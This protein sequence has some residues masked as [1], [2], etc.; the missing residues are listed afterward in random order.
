M[1]TRAQI[2]GTMDAGVLCTCVGIISIW[3]PPFKI[4][5]PPDNLTMGLVFNVNKGLGSTFEVVIYIITFC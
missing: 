3:D 5:E 1:R 2:P 4:M